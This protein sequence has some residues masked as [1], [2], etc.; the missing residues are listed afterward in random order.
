MNSEYTAWV[1]I[2]RKIADEHFV[3]SLYIFCSQF[4]Y[5]N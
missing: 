3:V 2:V 4:I 5:I 1:N